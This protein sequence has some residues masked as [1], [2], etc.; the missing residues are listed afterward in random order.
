MGGCSMPA[1]AEWH[2]QAN[3]VYDQLKI[4]LHNKTGIPVGDIFAN[5]PLDGKYHFTAHGLR[6]WSP[7]LEAC[8][9][10]AHYTF[11]NPIDRDK[12][13]EAETVL[14]VYMIVCDALGV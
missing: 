1:H 12:M 2:A 6:A 5:D 4:C 9:K 13:E 10:A 8:F 11:P 7:E 3:D 14:N